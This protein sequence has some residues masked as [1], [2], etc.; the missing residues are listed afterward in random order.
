MR[1]FFNG[2]TWSAPLIMSVNHGTE[3]AI[4]S[5]IEYSDWAVAAALIYS[6][7]LTLSEMQQVRPRRAL[8]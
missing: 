1:A 6:C 3:G 7:N 5:G 2:G 8:R 4:S